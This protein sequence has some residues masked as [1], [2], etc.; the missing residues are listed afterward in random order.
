[1]I[2]NLGRTASPAIRYRTCDVVVPRSDPC[3][4]GRTLRRIEGGILSRTDD[5]IN[6]RGVNVYPSALES[7]VHS[8]PEIAEF[9]STVSQSGALRTLSL[10][11]ELTPFLADARTIVPGLSHQL[12]E[13]LALHVPIRVVPAGT[14][15]RF[16]MK[17]RRF[18][19]ET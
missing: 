15:P 14:L 10:E 12:L 9:R 11:I 19:V 6:I 16:E 8:F 17:A 4:C 1:V 7:V 3:P 2:T 5:L 13:A 18:V